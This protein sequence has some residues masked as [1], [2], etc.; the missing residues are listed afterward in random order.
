M[1]K[2]LL[3][4]RDITA[5]DLN[6]IFE[7]SAKLK[8]ERGK[9]DFKPLAG[10][11]IGMIF[12]KS[13]TRTRV[14][15]EVG[16]SELGG[17]PLYLDQ[18]KMQVGR[19]ET[20]AD[21]ANVLSRYLHGIVIRT[22]SHADVEELAEVAT[23]PVVNALTDDYHPCQILTDLFTIL[24][25]SGRIQGVKVVFFGDGRS[26]IANSLILAAKLSGM[27]LVIAA[28][29]EFSPNAALIDGAP[30]IRWEKDPIKASADADYLYTDVFV[31][32]GFEEEKAARLKTLSPYEVNMAAIRAAKPSVKV[33]HC[34][35]A[36]RGE[37][38]A[39]EV[40]DSDYSIV[41]DQ[42]ENRLHV[43]KAI[44]MLLFENLKK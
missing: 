25:Y 30:N 37:E 15:F 43:Q 5:D 1:K 10:K 33:L 7:L 22:Y 35:P 12:A 28:P 19:G 42:A 18:S 24:E 11:S 36:H 6:A 8:R 14:S 41:F 31:S 21:T 3:T 16:I 39:A 23:I 27:E 34:L 44:L 2:D 40:M 4:L 17:N 29:E 26:N 20:V 38:I 9:S 32:M 13:S